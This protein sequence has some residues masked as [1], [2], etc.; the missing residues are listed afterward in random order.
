[1]KRWIGLLVL[2]GLV[3]VLGCNDDK[4]ST[5]PD[6]DDNGNYDGTITA[7]ITGDLELDFS[8]STAY[9]IAE[10]GQ[11]GAAGLMQ[12]QGIVMQGADEYMIDIQVYRDPAT[13]TYDLAFPPVDGVGSVAKNDTGNFSESGSVTFTQVGSGKL[14]GTFEF[15]AFRVIGVGEMVTT[16]V[17]DG[18]F[19]V[20]VIQ[21]D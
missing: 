2:V 19:D 8:C 16:T 9:G 7:T 10:A 18:T 21:I 4:K 14:A 15:V 20:P 3:A 12:I 1:M 11:G 5:T 17:A 6:G 13:G